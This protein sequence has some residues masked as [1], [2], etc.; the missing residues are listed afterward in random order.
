[1]KRLLSV[2]ITFVLASAFSW[3]APQQASLIPVKARHSHVQRHH[4]HKAGKHHRPKRH[5]R[6][7]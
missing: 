6:S 3:A 2:L 7:V 4:A 5:H 1:M